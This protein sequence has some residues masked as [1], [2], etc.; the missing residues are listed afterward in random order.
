MATAS[1]GVTGSTDS[2]AFQALLVMASKDPQ[3]MQATQE[4]PA[5]RA[6]QEKGGP[7]DWAS[8]VPKASV[9]SLEMLESLESQASP[10][11]QAPQA[12]QEK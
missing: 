10:D 9:V 4:H 5:L 11:L 3:G 12:L 1:R 2:Q 7:Q 6:F 8:Q